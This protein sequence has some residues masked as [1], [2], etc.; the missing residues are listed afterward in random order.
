MRKLIIFI[1]SIFIILNITACR[2]APNKKA[3]TTDTVQQT[4]PDAKK[5]SDVNLLFVQTAK[6]ATLK[7]LGQRGYYTLKLYGINPYLIY[8]SER[9]KRESGTASVENFIKAWST[10]ENNFQMDN[11]N[12]LLSAA[13]IDN[14]TN[15]GS[16]FYLM[17]CSTPHY[18]IQKSTLSYVVKPLPKHELLFEYIKFD[19]VT[20]LID[21]RHTI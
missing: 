16:T 20:L 2:K 7:K 18:D 15:K 5:D 17:T 21:S 11:P 9:P 13:M 12:V 14:V 10:G 19:Y 8:Y 4:T 6:A 3:V 1:A